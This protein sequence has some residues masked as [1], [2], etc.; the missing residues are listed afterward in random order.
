LP[1]ILEE[2]LDNGEATKPDHRAVS[3]PVDASASER[4][5][6][7]RPSAT[8]FSDD[9]ERVEK[10]HRK[11]KDGDDVFVYDLVDDAIE[12]G[13]NLKD[14][15]SDDQ[16]E[17][18]AQMDDVDNDLPNPV[19]NDDSLDFRSD[20]NDADEEDKKPM[21]ERE[22]RGKEIFERWKQ[23]VLEQLPASYLE[24]F[25]EIG[26]GQYGAKHFPVMILGPYDV[27]FDHSSNLRNR[28]ISMFEKVCLVLVF[29]R[30]LWQSDP[31]DNW[32]PSRVQ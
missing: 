29:E 1:E 5:R 21:A 6:G 4:G 14:S 31:S 11:T 18:S 17:N 28:W 22:A 32:I 30:L 20:D 3:S 8:S 19:N 13:G 25:G 2:Q 24:T 26:F 7:R 23:S 9:E 15:S 16:D 12:D 27:P 10:Q